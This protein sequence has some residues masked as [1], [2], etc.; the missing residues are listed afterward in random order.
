MWSTPVRTE[1]TSVERQSLYQRHRGIGGHLSHGVHD[2]GCLRIAAG[3]VLL[4]NTLIADNSAATSNPDVY[5]AVLAAS[6]YNLVGDGTGLSGISDD[7]D[8][9]QIGTGGSPIDPELARWRTTAVP[10]KPMRCVSVARPWTPDRTSWPYQ[11][12]HDPVP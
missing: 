10:R 7:Q 5:G 4:H 2:D 12:C 3:Y 11:T 6:S 9:N 1:A 8:G